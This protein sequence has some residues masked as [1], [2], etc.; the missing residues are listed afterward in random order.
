VRTAVTL[1]VQNIGNTSGLLITSH[2]LGAPGVTGVTGADGVAIGY[3]PSGVADYDNARHSTSSE[4]PVSQT[5]TPRLNREGP[6]A[7]RP[8][9]YLALYAAHL[10]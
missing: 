9:S 3:H 1:L 2:L 5:S 8:R 4:S 10:Q 7:V 6:P